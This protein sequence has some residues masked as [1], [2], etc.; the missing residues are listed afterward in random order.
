MS[1]EIETLNVPQTTLLSI[2][3]RLKRI[4]NILRQVAIDTR[5]TVETVDEIGE[6]LDEVFNPDEDDVA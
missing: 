1:D 6:T 2:D 3:S 4:E 5:D